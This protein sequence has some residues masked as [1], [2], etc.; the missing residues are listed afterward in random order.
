M[1]VSFLLI[2]FF[3]MNALLDLL[4]PPPHRHA[5]SFFI[6][7]FLIILL[8]PT[9]SLTNSF[10]HLCP[11]LP[12][13]CK[14][15]DDLLLLLLTLVG[16]NLTPWKKPTCSTGGVFVWGDGRRWR[17][18]WRVVQ[19]FGKDLSLWTSGEVIFSHWVFP[20]KYMRKTSTTNPSLSFPSIEAIY[21][22]L[23][24]KSVNNFP[25]KW[26]KLMFLLEDVYVN[27]LCVS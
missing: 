23:Q 5:L 19:R 12:L 21:L 9:T 13:L 10:L 15:C 7:Y 6:Y 26:H 3:S 1:F 16:I 4:S 27:L 17:R 2:D 14:H 8:F 20:V 22:Y 24:L 11:L 18:G 25:L